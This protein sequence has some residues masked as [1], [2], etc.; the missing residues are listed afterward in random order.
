MFWLPIPVTAGS[1]NSRPTASFSAVIGTKGSGHG[2]LGDPNGVAIDRTGNIYVAEASNHRVQKLAPDGTFVAEWKGPE[3]GF[4]GPRRIAVGPD[5]S[6]YVVDQGRN[7]IVKFSP[8]GQVLATW[9]SA[10]SGDGQ[11]NDRLRSQSIRRPTKFMSPIHVT[12]GIQVF[13]SNGKFLT[14]WSVPEWG[15]PAGL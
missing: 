1:K 11:F 10:G 7:R 6:I 3:P 5:D 12:S 15:R 2:Q 9:G 8:D 4:Y 13:D 14:K